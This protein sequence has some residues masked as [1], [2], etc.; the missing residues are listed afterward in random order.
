MK[1]TVYLFLLIAIVPIY[2]KIIPN[3]IQKSARLFKLFDEKLPK[4]EEARASIL[5]SMWVQAFIMK[6]GIIKQGLEKKKLTLIAHSQGGLVCLAFIALF[7]NEFTIE[8][9]ITVNSPLRGITSPPL[10]TYEMKQM[11]WYPD[12][13]KKFKIPN[14]SGHLLLYS[15]PFQLGMSLAG[16]W[17]NPKQRTAYLQS[18]AFLPILYGEVKSSMLPQFKKNVNNL[19]EI[20]CFGS[21]EDQMVVP[22]NS[23]LFADRLIQSNDFTQTRVYKK[24]LLGLKDMYKQGKIK[25]RAGHGSHGSTEDFGTLTERFILPYLDNIDQDSTII[26]KAG[27]LC[28]STY[29]KR[30]GEVITENFAKKGLP[31]PDIKGVRIEGYID[32]DELKKLLPKEVFNRKNPIQP[33]ELLYEANPS[34]EFISSKLLYLFNL[35]KPL[36]SGLLG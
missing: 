15:P 19:K 24:N 23:S 25:L 21:I 12:L 33:A 17:N 2:P 11:S 31:E 26:L 34:M 8:R 9:L 35:V 4:D 3:T 36:Y 28:R 10:N 14:N 29:L 32:I 20:I 18:C 16:F 6:Q 30:I 1:K 5:N 7:G 27:A 22:W 13:L